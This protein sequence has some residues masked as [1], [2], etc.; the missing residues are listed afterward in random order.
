M[1]GIV[2]APIFVI[3]H[4]PVVGP[5]SH[6]T[7]RYDTCDCVTRVHL[8]SHF[9]SRYCA[10]V[11]LSCVRLCTFTG[12]DC[13]GMEAPPILGCHGVLPYGRIGPVHRWRVHSLRFFGAVGVINNVSAMIVVA[14]LLLLMPPTHCVSG[15]APRALHV[16]RATAA[17]SGAILRSREMRWNVR[18]QYPFVRSA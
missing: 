18:D 14:T 8:R 9:G 11:E 12:A 6:V 17:A 15:Q 16:W 4:G 10:Q 13:S 3:V 1:F 2:H 5:V 7:T